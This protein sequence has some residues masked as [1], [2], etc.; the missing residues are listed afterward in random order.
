MQ[1]LGRLS[2]VAP[3]SVL[4]RP[5]YRQWTDRLLNPGR[6]LLGAARAAAGGASHAGAETRGFNK[7]CA[8]ELWPPPWIPTTIVHRELVKG[9]CV[10]PICLCEQGS[11]LHLSERD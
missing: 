5:I 2:R 6:G 10:E 4:E 1:L 7:F 9:L 8:W 3:N 11:R